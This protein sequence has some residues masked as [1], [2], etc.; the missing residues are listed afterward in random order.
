VVL[1]VEMV[2]VR[3]MNGGEIL[4]TSHAAEPLHG[5][6]SPSKRKVRMLR[7]V[8]E[9]ANGFLLLRVADDAS[10]EHCLRLSHACYACAAEQWWG[11]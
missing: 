6:F 4:Q 9:P 1:L 10:D 8:V 3:G 7:A 5:A 11:A 2:A